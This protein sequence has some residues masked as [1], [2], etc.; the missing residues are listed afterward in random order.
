[1][2]RL[3]PF[4]RPK[5]ESLQRYLDWWME[6]N[7]AKFALSMVI[8]GY[9]ISKDGEVIYPPPAEPGQGHHMFGAPPGLYGPSLLTA[10][11]IVVPKEPA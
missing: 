1:V 9:A 7:H 2:T 8:Y 11:E 3:A 6:R 4:K 5:G 10:D